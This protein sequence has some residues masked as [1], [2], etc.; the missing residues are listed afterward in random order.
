MNSLHNR[1]RSLHWIPLGDGNCFHPISFAY[2]RRDAQHAIDSPRR[3]KI[4]SIYAVALVQPNSCIECKM[5][6][7]LEP[8]RLWIAPNPNSRAVCTLYITHKSYDLWPMLGVIRPSER[9][10]GWQSSA[11]TPTHQCQ[12]GHRNKFDGEIRAQ[13]YMQSRWVC[14][15]LAIPTPKT[16]GP[17]MSW[18]T[19]DECLSF[20]PNMLAV[21]SW[22]CWAPP[23]FVCA[24]VHAEC[25]HAASGD[26]MQIV[27]YVNAV[28]PL[29]RVNSGR[30]KL[31]AA[32]AYGFGDSLRSCVMDEFVANSILL[33]CMCSRHDR[34]SS[35]HTHTHKH[36]QQAA[37]NGLQLVLPKCENVLEW[38]L[39]SVWAERI[40]NMAQAHPTH[41]NGPCSGSHT[42][43]ATAAAAMVPLK[44]P[45]TRVHNRKVC[46]LPVCACECRTQAGRVHVALAR[47]RDGCTVCT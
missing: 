5:S 28:R 18:F 16:H 42:P 29:T 27:V 15:L 6:L 35:L 4:Y 25:I 11:V 44:L 22:M 33:H 31:R 17:Y 34:A 1:A 38:Q 19:E 46:A 10:I 20:G 24:C 41:V 39:W 12:S 3:E 30:W 47:H 45:R 13:L 26:K 7:P 32:I 36:G 43:L 14:V 8:S 37:L 21:T 40:N 9:G 23:V 2:A